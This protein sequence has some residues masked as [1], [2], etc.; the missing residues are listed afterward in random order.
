RP[1]ARG[2]TTSPLMRRRVLRSGVLVLLLWALCALWVAAA[3]AQ[4]ASGPREVL[5]QS[6]TATH[7][8]RPTGVRFTGAYHAAGNKKG[9][10][11]YLKRMIFYPPPGLRYDTSVP[12]RCSAPDAVLEAEG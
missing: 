12:A 4:P 2:G 8:N 3:A 1:V 6:F 11:P 5:D 7:A 10:P 9:N